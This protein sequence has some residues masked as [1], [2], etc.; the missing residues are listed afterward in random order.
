MATVISVSRTGNGAS[1]HVLWTGAAAYIDIFALIA[2]RRRLSARSAASH[3][4][5]DVGI[6]P[7]TGMLCLLRHLD[8]GLHMRVFDLRRDR[9]MGRDDALRRTKAGAAALRHQQLY[10]L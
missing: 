6:R 8:I 9:H 1:G 3:F 5:C 4:R 7:V 10:A 2:R